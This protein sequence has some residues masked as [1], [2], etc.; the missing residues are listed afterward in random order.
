M[1]KLNSHIAAI[2]EGKKPLKCGI[3]EKILY[4]ILFVFLPLSFYCALV[5]TLSSGI[6]RSCALEHCY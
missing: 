4:F 2:H 5:Q 1:V 6:V 3:S